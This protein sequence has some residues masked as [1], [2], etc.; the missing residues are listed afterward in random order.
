MSSKMN[1]PDGGCMKRQA[2]VEA[3][4]RQLE[5]WKKTLDYELQMMAPKSISACNEFISRLEHFE[6]Q[7]D[8]RVESAA[9]LPAPGKAFGKHVL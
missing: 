6:K 5:I 3:N 1:P 8:S 2:A 9:L 7:M 4:K